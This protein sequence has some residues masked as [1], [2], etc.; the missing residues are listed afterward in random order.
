MSPTV[1]LQK[2]WKF[3]NL[4]LHFQK[5]KSVFKMETEKKK[6]RF[7]SFVKYLITNSFGLFVLLML[8]VV[9]GAYLF[10]YL[11]LPYET[12]QKNVR[13]KGIVQL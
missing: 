6:C 13:F 12:E 1:K 11:E 9:G 10:I 2:S 7:S 4:I 3:L 8:Y 5:I